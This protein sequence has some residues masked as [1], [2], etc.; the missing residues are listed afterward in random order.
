MNFLGFKQ[1]SVINLILKIIFE[2]IFLRFSILWTGRTIF[3][4]P[5]GLGVNFLRHKLP[6]G[7]QRISF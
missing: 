7:G 6:S 1:V 5:R 4:Q 2:F 3:R